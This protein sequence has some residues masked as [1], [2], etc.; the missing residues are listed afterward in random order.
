VPSAGHRSLAPRRRLR[1]GGALVL[2]LLIAALAPRLASAKVIERVIAVV[3]DEIVLDT[4]LEQQAVGQLRAPP[5]LDSAAGKKAWEEHKR[6]VLDSLIDSR[7]LSQQAGELKLTVT[8]DEVDRALDEVKKQNQLDD[9]AFATAL[10]QQG[11]TLETYKKNLKRQI[12]ELKVLNTAVRSRV[13]VSDDEVRTYYQQNARQIGG[14]DSVHLKQILITVPDGAPASL[15]EQKQRLA[16][17]VVERAR[18][19]TA[20]AE[21]ARAYSEDEASKADGGD[22]GWVQKGSLLDPLDEVIA[23]MDAG[24]VR[25]PVRSSRGFHVLLL[26]ERKQGGLKPFDEVKEQLRKTLYDQQLDKATQSWLKEL[27]KR[28]HLDIRY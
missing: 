28:A 9:A 25:G 7:L 2:A 20:F 11:F 23:G 19:G 14:G 21:L 17:K 24:D 4:E 1:G 6:K 8:A 13:S 15:V 18:G 26:V 10:K 5:D 3:N 16:A 22:L 12:L 27:R